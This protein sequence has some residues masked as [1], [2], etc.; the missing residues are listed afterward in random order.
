MSKAKKCYLCGSVARH[1]AYQPDYD[2]EGNYKDWDYRPM[3]CY[4][5]NGSHVQEYC[6]EDCLESSGVKNA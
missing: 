6:T 5:F 1:E 2:M 3:C 4:C